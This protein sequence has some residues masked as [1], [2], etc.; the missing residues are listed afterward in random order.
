[1]SYTK[2]TWRNNQSPAIN[3]D[4]LNH[5]EQGIYDAHDGLASANNNMEL[6][7]NRLQAEIDDT[8]SDISTL[9]SNLAAETSARTQQDSVLSARMDTFTQLPS[10]STSGD[11][12]LIDIRVGA[13]GTTYPTAGDAVRGQVT[14]LKSDINE[15]SSITS[16]NLMGVDVQ[17]NLYEGSA[18]WSGEWTATDSASLSLASE[19]FMG[20]PVM[21]YSQSWRRYYKAIPVVAGKTYT[22]EAWAKQASEGTL[23]INVT[24]S[25]SGA[26]ATVSPQST[27]LTALANTWTKLSLTFTCTASGTVTPYITSRA[28]AFWFA[29]YV[30]AEGST[31]FSLADALNNRPTKNDVAIGDYKRYEFNAK[32]TGGLY[33]NLLIEKDI[34]IGTK[35][36][37]VFDSYS[38]S[39]LKRVRVDGRKGDGTYTEALCF[40][41]APKWGDSAEFTASENYTALRIQFGRTERED[42][43]SASVYLQTNSE[44]GV[45]RD[46]MGMVTQHIYH[47]EKDGSGDFTSFVDAIN[48][49]C[50]FMDSIVYVGAGTFDLL[51]ELGADYVSGASSTQMGLVLK[52]RVHV[53]CSSQTVLQM[54]YAGSAENVRQYLSALNAGVHGFTLEN[55]RI[56]TENVRYSFHDDLGGSGSTPYTNKYI[57]CTMIHKNGYY[58]D[59]I[60]GGLGENACIEIRG[61]YFEGDEGRPRLAYYHG[62][63]NPNVTTAQS[64]LTVCDNYFAQDG[65]FKM[66]KYGQSPKV[67]TAYV[68]N[69]SFGTAPSVDAGSVA[70]YDNVAIVAWNNEV[71]S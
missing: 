9:E 66:T 39:K 10:G 63:S 15:H 45:S 11:A 20:Y 43:V 22:F 57:N 60:G 17:Q 24:D 3:A 37:F 30:L 40:I 28:G 49:A 38:G 71:R 13:D 19:K 5:I 55:A 36:R 62:N 53:I 16:T 47:V 18:D 44:I 41:N 1:M 42:N 7:D 56:E 2:T 26:T 68:S 23:A 4:N 59:C 67:S 21:Y 32:S 61:C 69:N 27:T 51:D 48:T 65:T 12:E 46:L 35:V 64:R 52:N 25:T 6:M 31:V 54:K 34:T 50:Q 29:K 33:W 8:N 14:D 70:P 58:S